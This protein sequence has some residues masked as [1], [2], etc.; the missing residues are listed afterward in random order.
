MLRPGRGGSTESHRRLSYA[1]VASTLALVIALG[2]GTAWAAHHYLITSKKQIKPS[3]LRAL[4]GARGKQGAN[5]TNGTNGTNGRNGRNG[6]TGPTGAAGI[7]VLAGS[8]PSG[9]TVTGAWG[10]RYVA[11]QL[12]HNNSYLISYSLP[13]KAPAPLSDTSVNT[14][15]N[16][17]A[18]DPDPACTGTV[19]VPTA[20]AGKVCL[21]IGS[22]ANATVG[23]FSLIQ[24]GGGTTQPGDDYGFV[25]RI[26]DAGTVGNTAATS[27][28]GTWAYTAP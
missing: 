19:D 6:A 7:G 9:T 2:G 14:A 18:G 16:A 8:I 17:A 1:N 28:Q 11:P 27:A 4:H 23:G 15:A 20:P 22:S 26:L 25:V 12:A 3:V 21:Y 5:G 10:G 13:M 24:P